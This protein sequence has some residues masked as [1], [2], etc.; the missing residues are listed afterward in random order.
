MNLDLE[1]DH[2]LTQSIKI[3]HR[4]PNIRI[5]LILSVLKSGQ[6]EMSKA[7]EHCKQ[8]ISTKSCN[9]YESKLIFAENADNPTINAFVNS[10]VGVLKTATQLQ[11]TIELASDS[12]QDSKEE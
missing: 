9:P 8:Q 11:L 6:D 10:V 4:I 2:Q 7:I 1:T 5:C 12:K 3:L